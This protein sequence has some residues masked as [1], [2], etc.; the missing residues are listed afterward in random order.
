MRIVQVGFLLQCQVLGR[1]NLTC[2][3]K[4]TGQTFLDFAAAKSLMMSAKSMQ[5]R[6]SDSILI[7]A[8]LTSLSCVIAVRTRLVCALIG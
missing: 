3:T 5:R 2:H 6:T 8:R 1:L 4:F 7:M